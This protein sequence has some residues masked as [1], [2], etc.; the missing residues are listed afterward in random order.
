MPSAGQDHSGKD[1]K[2]HMTHNEQA[3]NQIESLGTRLH[4][5]KVGAFENGQFVERPDHE[6]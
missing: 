2:Q 1:S 6:Q 5:K 3:E 4:R